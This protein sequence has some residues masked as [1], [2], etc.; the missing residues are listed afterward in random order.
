MASDAFERYALGE[1]L[2]EKLGGRKVLAALFTTYSFD[3][4]FFELHVLPLLFA[5]GFSKED[6]VRMVQLDEELH[7]TPVAVYYDRGAVNA[8]R[9]GG[10]LG[11]Q[12]FG[13]RRAT[14]TGATKG[15]F[16]PK[17]CLA[18]VDASEG[19]EALLVGV[20]SANLTE[21]GHW[22]NVECAWIDEVA[23]GALC[24]Y[25]EDLTGIL[26]AIR[27][28]A[29]IFQTQHASLE[30]I[31]KFLRRVDQ[32]KQRTQDGWFQ[33]RLF[34]GQ[35]NQGF[36][37]FLHNELRLPD[38][39]YHL[40]IISPFFDDGTALRELH[41][42]LAPKS[43]RL[44]LP[45]RDDNAATVERAYFDTVRAL[46]NA[47][48]ARF[49]D[50]SYL[51]R[52]TK[53][54]DELRRTVHAKVYRLWSK[55]EGEARE[56]VVLGLVN[57][58]SAAHS[59]RR[60]GNLEVAVVL[61][62][63]EPLLRPFLLP[64]EQDPVEFGASSEVDDEKPNTDAARPLLLR[65]HWASKRLEAFWDASALSPRI[66]LEAGGVRLPPEIDPL[67]QGAWV[68]LPASL[69]TALAEHL[70]RTSLVR[71][72]VPD[73]E[74]SWIVVQEEDLAQKPSLLL[75]LTVEEI[76]RYW[77]ALSDAQRQ[78]LLERADLRRVRALEAL[79]PLPGQDGMF[80]RFAGVFHAFERLREHV[81]KA[82]DENRPGDAEYRLF[83]AKHDSLPSLLERVVNDG[84]GECTSE[85][86]DHVSDPTTKLAVRYATLLSAQRLLRQ[87]EGSIGG[88][89]TEHPEDVNRLRAMLKADTLRTRVAEGCGADGE[90]F[91]VW[92]DD[93][94]LGKRDRSE[95]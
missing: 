35:G 53:S 63:R 3:P 46:P 74:P 87:L 15:C 10:S 48:W 94:F 21:A 33:P 70:P 91:V 73:A 36:A 19:E 5:R 62:S 45:L 37:D 16:H 40:E 39:T 81:E 43:T 55:A 57:L 72:H 88:F 29:R 83:G 67:A 60:A 14:A 78:A 65:F 59:P 20:F 89:L 90:A 9:G 69:A 28:E 76:L 47:A 79:P 8:G 41:A 49:V 61:E 64:I 22:T 17:L 80:D 11:L 75:H 71:V 23:A 93:W 68:D 1:A 95:E 2:R 34:Y 25:Q 58:T 66:A 26:G 32:A 12:S 86:P 77:A 27:E 56:F 51:R 4:G 85:A 54:A 6:T 52:G 42:A 82:V 38:D 13:I 7:S 44:Y 31:L 30:R 92:F 50:P 18:L 24:S 84:D